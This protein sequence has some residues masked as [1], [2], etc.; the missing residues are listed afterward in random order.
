[1]KKLFLLSLSVFC[2]FFFLSTS[3]ATSFFAPPNCKKASATNTAEFCSS[4]KDA[5]ICH[6][7][8]RG[9]PGPVCQ[10]MGMSEIYRRMTGY[11]GSMEAACNAQTEVPPQE[12]IDGWN[13]YR[14][15]G[16][17]SQGRLCS[18]TGSYCEKF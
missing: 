12:C 10:M 13:C 9:I 11:Y 4:F 8:A 17:D 6:C 7:T 18:G 5:A 16:T 14:F 2:F 3:N 15:G 1:M